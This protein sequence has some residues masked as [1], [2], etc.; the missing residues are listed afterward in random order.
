MSPKSS[1]VG[2]EGPPQTSHSRSS[3]IRT[4]SSSGDS[5]E[6]PTSSKHQ[7]NQ[8]KPSTIRGFFSVKEPSALA[9]EQLAKQQRAELAKKRQKYPSGISRG[10][11]PLSAAQDYKNQKA[12]AKEKAKM[13]EMAKIEAG[14]R[15]SWETKPS[16]PGITALAY[17]PQDPAQQRPLSGTVARP[18]E[19]TR[20]ESYR[21]TLDPV[22]ENAVPRRS[23][24]TASTPSMPPTPSNESRWQVAPWEEQ[25]AELSN[26]KKKGFFSGF[27]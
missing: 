8:T 4:N 6:R 19:T 2:S 16:A 24:S 21:T 7:Q 10:Q 17:C 18:R 15:N 22:L 13:Y 9:F 3:S 5:R 27:G 20:T 11:M 25:D 23:I 14:K 1:S 26:N 12:A